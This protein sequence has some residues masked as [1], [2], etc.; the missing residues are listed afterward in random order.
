MFADKENI[1]TIL[2]VQKVF[3]IGSMPVFT[4]QQLVTC[5]SEVFVSIP[6]M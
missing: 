6:G 2:T 1:N 3:S 5:V 4:G